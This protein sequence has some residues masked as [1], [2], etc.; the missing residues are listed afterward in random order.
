[1]TRAGCAVD[2]YRLCSHVFVEQSQ[3]KKQP[4]VPARRV[5]I[6]GQSSL[7]DL[8]AATPCVLHFERGGHFGSTWEGERSLYRRFFNT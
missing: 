7:S 3:T 1:M 6:P 8:T 2:G 5:A 4:G